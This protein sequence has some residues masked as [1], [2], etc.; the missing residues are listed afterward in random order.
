MSYKFTHSDLAKKLMTKNLVDGV[1]A[2][3]KTMAPPIKRAPTSS[4]KRRPSTKEQ[5]A[6]FAKIEETQKKRKEYRETY[7]TLQRL[8]NAAMKK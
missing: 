1:R 5:E 8:L 3:L 2:T 4:K 7:K 6:L